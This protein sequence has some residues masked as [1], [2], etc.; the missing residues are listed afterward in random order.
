MEKLNK[1]KI[2]NGSKY[3]LKNYIQFYVKTFFKIKNLQKRAH[4]RNIIAQ[5]KTISI[6]SIVQDIVQRLQKSDN[7]QCLF[8]ILYFEKPSLVNF[9]EKHFF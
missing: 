2:L 9:Q 8:Y 1:F 3:S 4:I 7:Y 6:T 5:N